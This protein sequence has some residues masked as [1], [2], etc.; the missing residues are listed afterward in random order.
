MTEHLLCKS[1]IMGLCRSFLWQSQTQRVNAPLRFS[2]GWTLIKWN[3]SIC[4]YRQINFIF[5]HTSG[6]SEAPCCIGA[7]CKPFRALKHAWAGR[8][9]EPHLLA[10]LLLWDRAARSSGLEQWSAERAVALSGYSL[11]VQNLWNNRALEDPQPTTV[12][13]RACVDL[14]RDQARAQAWQWKR[15]DSGCFRALK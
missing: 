8:S 10:L 4:P 14:K 1:N 15:K 12:E 11:D 5:S 6:R 7:S 9:T 2:Q 13:E 3:S